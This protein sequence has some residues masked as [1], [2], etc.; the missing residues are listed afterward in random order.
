M[1]ENRMRTKNEETEEWPQ[2]QHFK[3]EN[4]SQ[5]KEEEPGFSLEIL[6]A[7]WLKS[8]KPYCCHA[9]LNIKQ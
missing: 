5:T 4:E 2:A 6:D 7:F 3:E 9:K 1:E 8:E